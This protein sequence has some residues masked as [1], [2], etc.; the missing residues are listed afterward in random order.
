MSHKEDLNVGYDHTMRNSYGSVNQFLY[1]EEVVPGTGSGEAS[2]P[3]H[4][5]EISEI[6]N[7]AY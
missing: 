5:F 2:E 3:G 1:D 6:L 4:Y 7:T